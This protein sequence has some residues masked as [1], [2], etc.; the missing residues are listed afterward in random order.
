VPYRGLELSSSVIDAL[1]T[2][3]NDFNKNLASDLL[4]ACD[5]MASAAKG[6]SYNVL[7]NLSSIKDKDFTSKMREGLESLLNNINT[8]AKDI[9]NKANKFLG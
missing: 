4:S 9:K 1:Q 6:F 5:I 7:V 3:S 2:L 8:K